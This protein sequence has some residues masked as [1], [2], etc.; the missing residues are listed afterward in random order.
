MKEREELAKLL[1]DKLVDRDL[2]PLGRVRNLSPMARGKK[3]LVFLVE[4]ERDRGVLR[5][6]R[7]PL[8]MARTKKVYGLC[9]R[10]GVSVARIHFFEMARGWLRYGLWG[11]SLEEWVAPWEGEGKGLLEELARLHTI[12]RARWGD[13]LWGKRGDW[14]DQEMDKARVRLDR[15]SMLRG[16]EVE[17]Y[18]KWLLSHRALLKPLSSYSLVHGDLAP[19]NLGMKGERPVFIDL[20]RARFAHPLLDVAALSYHFPGVGEG[21]VADYLSLL[22][23]TGEDWAFY[24]FLFHLKRLVRALKHWRRGEEGWQARVEAHEAQLARLV[25]A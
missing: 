22:G 24:L 3:G 2:D 5:F 9:Q 23:F 8:V 4:G 15:W 21:A 25:E 11:L 14:L 12:R 7:D 18:W 6:Y 10:G 20:D 16:V 19:S 13:P 1:R 17:G